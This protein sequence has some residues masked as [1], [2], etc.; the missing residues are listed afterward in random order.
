VPHLDFEQFKSCVESGK[1]LER[2]NKSVAEANGQGITGTPSFIVAK[3]KGD[4]ADGVVLIGAQSYADFENLL[5]EQS[6]K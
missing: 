4:V 3:T 1:Y 2:I 5:K 6:S